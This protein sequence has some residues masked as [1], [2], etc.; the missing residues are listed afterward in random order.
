MPSKMAVSVMP[1]TKK[2]KLKHPFKTTT[3]TK[4]QLTKGSKTFLRIEYY[5]TNVHSNYTI[6]IM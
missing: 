5:K 4:N 2:N 3:T 1:R 6:N